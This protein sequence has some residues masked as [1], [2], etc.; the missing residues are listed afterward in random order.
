MPTDHVCF[1]PKTRILTP[2]GERQ[3]DVLRPGDLVETLDNGPQPIRWIGQR[4]RRFPAG[5]HRHKPILIKA[6]SLG[7]DTP[8]CDLEVSPQHRMLIGGPLVEEVCGAPEVLV[9]A[10]GLVGLPGI[11]SMNGKRQAGYISVL[12]DRHQVLIAE[13]AP[14]ESFYPE[15]T[16]LI[17]IG[18]RMRNEILSL[19]PNLLED[20]ATYGRTARPVLRFA[21]ARALVSQSLVRKLPIVATCNGYAGLQR[22]G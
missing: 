17:M 14:S 15:P 11:R 19:F 5:P 22:T 13:G 4:V 20:S 10:K 1:T 2:I 16:A 12:L 9:L 8:R 18:M 6:G 21:H 7:K 3:V